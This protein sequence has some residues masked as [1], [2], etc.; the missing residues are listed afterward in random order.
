MSKQEVIKKAWGVHFENDIDE[1]GFRI[2]NVGSLGWD[3]KYFDIVEIK[4]FEYSIRPKS[5]AVIEN[6][7]G[8]IKIESEAD[9]PNDSYMYWVVCRDGDIK[10]LNDFEYYKKYIIPEFTVTHYQPITKP[11]KPIY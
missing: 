9:L 6:N 5:L 2:S 8:W 11:L 7:N 4:K 10:L 3:S 1:N